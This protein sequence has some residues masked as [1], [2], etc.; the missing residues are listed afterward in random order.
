MPG[1]SLIICSRNRPELLVD[2]VKSVLSGEEVPSEIIIIDQSDL[3]NPILSA[4]EPN[5]DCEFNY[6]KT[7]SVGVSKARNTAIGIARHNLLIFLDDDMLVTKAWF[8]SIVRS[9]IEAGP[10]SVVTGKVLPYE[11]ETNQGFAPSTKADDRP[12]VYKGRIEKDVLF[13]NNMAAYR[14]AFDEVGVFDERLGPGTPFLAAEDNDLCFRLLEAGYEIIY[15]PR[16]EVY[17]RAWRSKHEFISME[18]NYGY[19]QGAFY[20]KH[21]SLRDP[22]ILRRMGKDIFNYSARVPF[23]VWRKFYRA[24]GDA[25]FAL[26]L[27]LGAAHWFFSQ[28]KHAYD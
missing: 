17:H 2:T 24:K 20:A 23:R 9:L 10:H 16:A 6:L 21:M 8:G 3:T 13:T 25:L 28:R 18:W 19:G 14:S 26:G 7:E 22:F 11:K 15:E 27:M 1:T 4:N 12:T 5:P